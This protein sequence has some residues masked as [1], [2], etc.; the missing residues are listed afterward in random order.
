MMIPH[1]DSVGI[2][3]GTVTSM[4]VVSSVSS[5]LEVSGSGSSAVTVVEFVIVPVALGVTSILTVAC[6][7]FARLPRLH[8]TTPLNSLQLPW[9]GVA[10][11]KLTPAGSVSVTTTLVASSG[12]LFVI[13]R[14]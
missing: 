1:S 13:V 8:V 7:P 9:L 6:A 5:L 3:I 11:T 2:P 4:T 10:D 14:V 12:P